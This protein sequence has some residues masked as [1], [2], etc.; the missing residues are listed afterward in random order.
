[1]L[2]FFPRFSFIFRN[3]GSDICKG[4][5]VLRKGQRLGPSELG[6]LATVGVTQVKSFKAPVIGVMSTGNE[7]RR[8]KIYFWSLLHNLFHI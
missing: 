7:V 4:E 3:I 8:K 2:N 6:I 5:K 1:M